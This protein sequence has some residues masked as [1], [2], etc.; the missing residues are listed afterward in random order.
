VP[1]CPN[2][3]ID[4]YTDGWLDCMLG[5]MKTTTTRKTFSKA[6]TALAA[7]LG[8]TDP[9]YLYAEYRD[10]SISKL[11]GGYCADMGFQMWLEERIEEGSSTVATVDVIR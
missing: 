8:S 3:P 2:S 7:Q 5:I 6:I 9:R 4:L 11:G 10:M 1:C